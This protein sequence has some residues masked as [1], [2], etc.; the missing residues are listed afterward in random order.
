M[1]RLVILPN[2]ISAEIDRRLDEEIAKHPNAAPDRELFRQQLINYVD[3]HGV[4][5]DFSLNRTVSA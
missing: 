1:T 4:V 5:P 3:E 2:Y